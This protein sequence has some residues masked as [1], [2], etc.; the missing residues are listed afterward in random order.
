MINF[1]LKKLIIYGYYAPVNW[2]CSCHLDNDCD[3]FQSQN[4]SFYFVLGSVVIFSSS[5]CA[6]DRWFIDG[7]HFF[8]FL[9]FIIS[10]KSMYLS[11]LFFGI[12][13]YIFIISI[14]IFFLCFF[15]KILIVL[16]FILQSKFTLYYFFQFP[17]VLLICFFL[18][19]LFFF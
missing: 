9:F 17:I 12:L 7:G 15:I 18:L 4:L 10:W 3:I 16:R 14:S 11:S 1:L 6:D 2:W 8:S 5:L 13:I 19:K